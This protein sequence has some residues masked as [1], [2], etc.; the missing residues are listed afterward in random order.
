MLIDSSML[1]GFQDNREI[2][3]NVDSYVIYHL[4]LPKKTKK[5]NP[6]AYDFWVKWH[7]FALYSQNFTKFNTFFDI[8]F[9]YARQLIQISL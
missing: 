3:E 2:R 7:F 8:F 6:S 1:F 5:E 9:V 4:L